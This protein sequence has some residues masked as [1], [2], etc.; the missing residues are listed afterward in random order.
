MTHYSAFSLFREALRGNTGW[1]R[2]WRDATPKPAYD[3]VIVGGGG[4]G[5]ATAY[6]LAKNHGLTNVAV[7]EKGWIGGGNTGRNTTIIRSNYMIDGNT[8][9]YEHSMKLWEGMS[10]DLNFNVMYSPRGQLNLGHSPAQMDALA[11]RG[12]IMRMNGIDAELLS[13][14]EVRQRVPILDYSDHAR[15]PIHGGLWQQRAGTARHDAVAWGYARGA[16]AQ[17]VDIVQNCE[18]TGYLREHDRIVGVETTRG[19]I[20]AKK[21]GLAVAG[22]TG[23]LAA[24]AGLRLPIETHVLQAFVTEAIK[25]VIDCVVAFGAVHFYVSQSDKGGLVMGGDLD[26]H[27]S[28][29]QRGD[30]PIVEETMAAA[31]ALVPLV[32]RLRLL[33]H[34]AGVMDMTMDGSP[35]I[36]RAPVD[37][38]YINGGWCYGGFK[39][40]PASGWCFAHTIAHDAPHPLN[41]RF[42]LD[43]FRRGHQLDEKGMGPTPWAH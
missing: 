4:H 19:P 42:T 38:L 41:A 30:L 1:T 34:W 32:S 7:I 23:Q 12:N 14:E 31:K 15:F 33:R 29:G 5:L 35:I 22:H 26:G 24:K 11:R 20:R 8:A 13:R 6:Y 36:C 10:R 16:D 28:Y 17:G 27:N 18:V 40:T 2:A 9:F 43:R 37:G 25:P 21:V 39:A 3:V